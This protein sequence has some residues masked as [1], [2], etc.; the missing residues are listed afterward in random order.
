MVAMASRSLRLRG[1]PRSYRDF[2]ANTITGVLAQEAAIGDGAPYAAGTKVSVKSG[3]YVERITPAE[4]NA[5]G[6]T[7]DLKTGK[8]DPETVTGRE[9]VYWPGG[10]VRRAV[11][12]HD[13][14]FD[15][16]DSYRIV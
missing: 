9:I 5:L 11:L 8:S 14:V 7:A 12:A 6:K 10:A 2:E 15:V 16:G 13:A 4:D 3:R 1:D